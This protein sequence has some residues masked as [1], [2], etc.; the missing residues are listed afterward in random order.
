MSIFNS[1]ED[2]I[3]AVWN[4]NVP[5]GS[6]VIVV[7][8]FGTEILETITTSRAWVLPGDYCLVKVEGITG[9]YPLERCIPA[10]HDPQAAARKP[11]ANSADSQ[12]ASTKA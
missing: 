1:A 5:V 4:E 3:V 6:K 10:I 9:G 7:K 2:R 8:N 11:Q 12:E